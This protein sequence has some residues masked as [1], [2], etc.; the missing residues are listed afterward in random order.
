M[1][2]IHIIISVVAH[3]IIQQA[4]PHRNG[5]SR[6]RLTYIAVVNIQLAEPHCR[7]RSQTL[8]HLLLAVPI[9]Q[10]GRHWT[11]V[12]R[13]HTLLCWL[14]CSGQRPTS[15][16]LQIKVKNIG[17]IH[18]YVH[19]HVEVDNIHLAE[20]YSHDRAKT[21]NTCTLLTSW[22]APSSSHY[23]TVDLNNHI[24]SLRIRIVKTDKFT[25]TN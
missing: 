10:E 25:K 15:W 7:G 17:A 23:P 21:L 18:C 20:P 8:Y 11:V 13:S 24:C 22:L 6:H 1:P 12:G 9:I 16:T 14:T 5:R 2:Y 4:E 3:T 19:W